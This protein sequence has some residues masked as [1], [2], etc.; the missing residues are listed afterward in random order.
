MPYLRGKVRIYEV[1]SGDVTNKFN[2]SYFEN[3]RSLVTIF[4]GFK[5]NP[6]LCKL[7]SD[8]ITPL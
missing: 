5:E 7:E 6:P 4:D 3:G 2:Y 1:K 8:A